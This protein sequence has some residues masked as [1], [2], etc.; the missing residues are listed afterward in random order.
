MPKKTLK[1]FTERLTHHIKRGH[2]HHGGQSRGP[3]PEAPFS[4]LSHLQ[5]AGL[6]LEAEFSE[7]P[8]SVFQTSDWRKIVLQE[9]PRTEDTLKLDEQAR[10]NKQGNQ[11]ALEHLAWRTSIKSEANLDH[12]E[13]VNK[14]S[15]EHNIP[16]TFYSISDESHQRN[17]IGTGTAVFDVEQI[18]AVEFDQF[19]KDYSGEFVQEGIVNDASR[20]I[21]WDKFDSLKEMR[22]SSRHL[23]TMDEIANFGTP[24]TNEIRTWLETRRCAITTQCTFDPATNSTTCDT[25]ENNGPLSSYKVIYRDKYTHNRRIFTVLGTKRAKLSVKYSDI[26]WAHQ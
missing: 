26:V 20:K 13:L 21:L 22:R 6:S 17:Q 2:G 3:G 8:K 18:V 4:V 19:L 10:A 1:S 9:A 11:A 23:D 15:G 25:V 5:A 12:I 7:P 14:V 24:P 16:V